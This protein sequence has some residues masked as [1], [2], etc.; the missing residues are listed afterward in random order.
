[1][2][3]LKDLDARLQAARAAHEKNT[4][5][6]HGGGAQ[7]GRDMATGIRSFM[8]MIGVLLGSALMGYALDALFGTGP[9][10]LFCFIFLGIFAALFNLYKLSRNLGTAIGS[11]GLQNPKKDDR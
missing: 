4:P 11:N 3:N 6:P 1:M 10:L 5:A 7:A 9:M 8:E 2:D